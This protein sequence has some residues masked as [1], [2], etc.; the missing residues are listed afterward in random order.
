MLTQFFEDDERFDI[1][2]LGS[3]KRLSSGKRSFSLKSIEGKY[4][5]NKIDILKI[6][7]K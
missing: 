2:S 4:K 7:I 5:Y 6:V 1:F 3:G